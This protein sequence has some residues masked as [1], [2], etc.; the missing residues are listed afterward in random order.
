MI[1]ELAGNQILRIIMKKVKKWNIIINLIMLYIIICVT[2][3]SF[4]NPHLTKTE[5]SMNIINFVMLD[6]K[7]K[8][9]R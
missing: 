2:I 8:D 4:K 6:F 9:C 1:L 3:G 7:I 5:I